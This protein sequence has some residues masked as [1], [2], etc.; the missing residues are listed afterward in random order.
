MTEP[1]AAWRRLHT[2]NE[3]SSG[4]PRA[5]DISSS[6]AVTAAIFRCADSGLAS[7]TVFGCREGLLDV[8]TWGHVIDT[9][10][11]A[12]LEYA[13]QTLQVPLIVVLGHH[14]CAAVETALRAWE[15]AD[16]PDGAARA[17]VEHV[18]WS[19]VR[20]HA[21]A[22]SVDAVAAAHAV[23]TGL[24]LVQ[25]SPV[26]ARQVD[27]QKCGIV[28]ATIDPVTGRLQTHATIGPVGERQDNLAECV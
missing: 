2:G 15:R 13:V 26:I 5:E 12:T 21:P 24:G 1:M 17:A 10:V 8:S 7:E 9:G 22:D 23:E 19:I 16:L 14:D 27:A 4:A 3:T 25:R 28:C 11:L 18:M 20:R 6:G